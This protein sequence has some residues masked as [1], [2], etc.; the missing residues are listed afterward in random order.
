MQNSYINIVLCKIVF[1]QNSV[2]NRRNINKKYY[3]NKIILSSFASG[4]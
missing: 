4:A 1:K 2:I 3:E